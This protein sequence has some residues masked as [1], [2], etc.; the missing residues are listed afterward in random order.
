MTL[1]TV[2]LRRTVWQRRRRRI[3]WRAIHRNRWRSPT[4][5]WDVERPDVCSHAERGNKMWQPWIRW[6]GLIL[7][8]GYL[9]FSH[10]CHGD[11]DNEL[12]GAMQTIALVSL[13]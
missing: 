13:R 3:A 8:G 7:L 5:K 6:A 2:A 1:S 9:L 4:S 11:E 12:F 10:G